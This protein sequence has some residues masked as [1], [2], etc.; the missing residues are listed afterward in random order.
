M[1]SGSIKYSTRS[2]DRSK[3][4]FGALSVFCLGGSFLGVGV[5]KENLDAHHTEIAMMW[6]FFF[7]CFFCL[8]II[9]TKLS[10]AFMLMVRY[11][12]TPYRKTITHQFSARCRPEE[13]LSPLPLVHVSHLRP[14][15]SHL[16]LLHN[17]PLRSNK[18][19]LEYRTPRRKMSSLT[20]PR[21]CILRRHCCQ[22]CHRLVLCTPVWSYLPT[23]T[24]RQT[25]T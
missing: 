1:Y 2:S 4:P 19:R 6:F 9:P 23:E 7:E 10:I 11:L 22:Y 18:F 16:L 13:D 8:A 12:R 14:N 3:I 15:E 17:L 5:H 20:R 25:N 21:R 24:K